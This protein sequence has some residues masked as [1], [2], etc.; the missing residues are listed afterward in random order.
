MTHTFLVSR[1][2]AAR[3]VVNFLALSLLLFFTNMAVANAVV[4]NGSALA[5]QVDGEHQDV[6]LV[7]GDSLSAAYGINES[8]GW[9]S[10]LQQK[11]DQDDNSYRVLNASISGDTTSGGKRRLKPLLDQW[12]PALVI[13]ELGGND[14]LRGVQPPV[15]KRNLARMIEQAQSAYAEVLLVGMH[16]PPNYGPRY[17]QAFHQ[18]YSTLAE[19]YSIS[20]V[21]FLLEGV[22]TRE[23]LMQAD[24]IHPT[25]EAQMTIL[26]NVWPS[27]KPLLIEE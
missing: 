18:L 20:L 17:T 22:A 13:L 25:A 14:G 4:G 23:G 2:N 6:I 21:P 1:D 12:Q 8:D 16:I 5:V 24:G 19:E 3:K 26:E 11:L 27:L 9:V 10:L 7:V 15:I